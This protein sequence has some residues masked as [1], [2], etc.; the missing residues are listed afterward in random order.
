MKTLQ[1]KKIEKLE[2]L[3]EYYGKPKED[4]Y[5][6]TIDY[7]KSELAALDKEIEQE[8]E[9]PNDEEIE[10]ECKN[11]FLTLSD[12]ALT[13]FTQGVKWARDYKGGK[14][15]CGFCGEEI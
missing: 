12:L 14:C 11:R 9:C 3:I 1:E 6:L 15:Y 2:E 5:K 8:D 10:V 4:Q 7:M 13:F